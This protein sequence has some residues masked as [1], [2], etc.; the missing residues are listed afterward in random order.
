MEKSTVHQA[1]SQVQEI[2]KVKNYLISYQA[3]LSSAEREILGPTEYNRR[4]ANDLGLFL[5]S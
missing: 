1:M 2:E 3:K 5:E 4:K